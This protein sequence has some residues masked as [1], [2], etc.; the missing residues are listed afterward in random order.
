MYYFSELAWIKEHI[1]KLN[2]MNNNDL[3]FYLFILNYFIKVKFL[4]RQNLNVLSRVVTLS[5]WTPID[6]YSMIFLFGKH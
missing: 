3:I 4:T 5:R 6:L 2:M 1:L